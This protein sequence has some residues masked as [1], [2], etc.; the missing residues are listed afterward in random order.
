MTDRVITVRPE[1]S[2]EQARARLTE[3]RFS[4][5]PVVDARNRVVG[6]VSAADL[7]RTDQRGGRGGRPRTVGGAMR[8]SVMCMSPE[9]DVNIVAHRLRTY[10][11][12]RV[13]PIV[14]HGFLVGVVTRADLLRPR[15]PGGK[16]G[17]IARRIWDL[18]RGKRP[19][20]GARWPVR[21]APRTA[22]LARLR[23]RDVMTTDVV[24][25]TE[26]T[27][28][29]RAAMLLI[30]NRFTALPVVDGAGMLV[31]LVSEADLVR[32]PLDGWHAPAATVAG[33]MSTDVVA[34]TPYAEIRELARLLSD[35]GLRLVPIVD[36]GRLVGVV[37]RGDV[38]RAY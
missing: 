31:G 12:L 5:L 2:V 34:R 27:P 22:R 3:H 14:D 18:V 37:S 10:G 9:A 21:T 28:T 7:L 16:L 36:H 20:T 35:G 19:A 1:T 4:A 38:L 24:T 32:D 15:P 29:K 26:N 8:T 11:H 17:R 13:M 25:V 30:S 23:A 33:A 6:M